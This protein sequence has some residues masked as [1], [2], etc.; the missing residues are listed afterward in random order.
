MVTSTDFIWDPD[1]RVPVRIT[2]TSLSYEYDEVY[3]LG[4]MSDRIDLTW[5]MLTMY[6]VGIGFWF[7]RICIGLIYNSESFRAPNYK[8]NFKKS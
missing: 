2:N 6:W 8:M 1:L 3:E 7:C 5:F 4:S